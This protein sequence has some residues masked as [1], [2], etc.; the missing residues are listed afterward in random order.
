ML[1]DYLYIWTFGQKKKACASLR[2]LWGV[3]NRAKAE[4]EN[5]RSCER[6][7]A[8]LGGQELEPWA[9]TGVIIEE[10]SQSTFYHMFL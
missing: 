2:C 6:S 4:N 1:V 3:V 9:G 5:W 7:R 10:F 8:F